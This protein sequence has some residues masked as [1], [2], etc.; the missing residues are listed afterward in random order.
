MWR[1]PTFKIGSLA[2][3]NVNLPETEDE[4]LEGPVGKEDAQAVL[5][6]V[7]PGED[8]EEILGHAVL[9]DEQIVHVVCRREDGYLGQGEAD[10][11]AHPVVVKILRSLFN[12]AKNRDDLTG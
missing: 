12:I 4:L 7:V 2:P 5:V 3:I 9:P 10:A 11:L 6:E 8:L 1:I